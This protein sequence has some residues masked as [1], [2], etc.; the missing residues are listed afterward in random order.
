M[1]RG[2]REIPENFRKDPE[3]LSERLQEFPSTVRLGSPKPY[4]LRHLRRPGHFQNS[5]PLST[6]GGASFFRSGSGEGLSEPV[7]EFPAVLRAFLRDR[8]TERERKR[9]LLFRW[10]SLFFFFQNTKDWRVRAR[11]E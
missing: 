2:I 9:S 3:M 6:A 5:L 8:D 1:E 10:L 7:M 4:N 11:A